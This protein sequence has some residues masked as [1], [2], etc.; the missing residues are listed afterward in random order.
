MNASLGHSVISTV[1][2]SAIQYRVPALRA[3]TPHYTV[4]Q[5]WGVAV[6]TV[7][8]VLRGTPIVQPTHH[9]RSMSTFATKTAI[10]LETTFVGT[11]VVTL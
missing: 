11:L 8:S 10:V 7:L 6:F 1:I 9:Y 2:A 4:H 5:E 3:I